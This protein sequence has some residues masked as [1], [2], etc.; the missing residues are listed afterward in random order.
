MAKNKLQKFEDIRKFA[1]VT[2]FVPPLPDTFEYKGKW[3]GSL[4]HNENPINLELACGKGEYSVGLGKMYTEEN[5]V[6]I[7]I[8][9]SRIW[10]GAKKALN[11]NLVNVHFIR[12][13][14]DHITEVFEEGEINDIWI[15]FPDPYLRESD[16]KK[17][18][19]SSKFLELYRQIARENSRIHLKTDDPTLY[20]FTMDVIREQGLELFQDIVDVYASEKAGAELKEIQTYYEKQ[21]IKAGKSIRYICFG[22]FPPE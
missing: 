17:R 11:Q 2:E 21:H 16:E 15:T 6:G 9:G 8:K 7:D 5:Y 20:N 18:L 3:S 4:F 12:M 19:T 13:Y 1:N 22:L 14:I 10:H